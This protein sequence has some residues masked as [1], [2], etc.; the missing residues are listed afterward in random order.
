MAAN[1]FLNFQGTKKATFVGTNSNVV[2][3]TLNSSLG[4]GV[5]ENGPTSNLHVVGNAYV[6]TGLTVGGTTT[7]TAFAGP[8]TG[9]VTGDGSGLTA[10][11][12]TNIA[13]GT[14]TAARI[15]D[16]WSNLASNVVRIETLET[17]NTVQ[18]GLITTL[19]TDVTDNASRITTLE[20]DV[21]DNASRITTLETDVTDNAS[22]ITTLESANTVQGGLI[23]A[24]ETDVTDNASRITTL[25]S[26]NAI[27]G[28]L[29]TAIETDVTDNASRITTLESANTVQGG[30]ITAIETD[31]TDNA[32]RITTLESANAIQG[33][34][35]TAIETDV[36][37]NASRI[38]TLESANAIQG[39]LIT[40]IE[41]DVASNASKIAF[42]T[43]T[44]D[45]TSIA[46]NLNVTGN[47]GIGT[48][49]P[50]SQFEVQGAGQTETTTFNQAGALGGTLALRDSGTSA[51]NGGAIMFGAPQGFWSAIKANMVDG[52]SNSIGALSFFTRNATGDSTMTN[53][54]TIL[55]TGNVGIGTGA[56]GA[57]LD[58]YKNSTNGAAINFES[59]G[60]YQTTIGQKSSGVGDRA[61][62]FTSYG[63]AATSNPVYNFL[64]LNSDA[65]AYNTIL[66]MTGNGNV[67]IGATDPKTRLHV[68]H[69]LHLQANSE[70]WNTTA[71]KGLYLR[72]SLT[73]GQDSAYIQSIDRTNTGT[74]YP[75]IFQAS[76]YD[77]TVGNATFAGNVTAGSF[78]GNAT[79]ATSAGSVT[80]GVYTTGDQTIGGTKTFSGNVTTG[81][82]LYVGTNTNNETAKT[83]Y[84]GGTYGDNG[85]DHCVIER[86][87]WATGTENQELLL[88]SGN[89]T[90]P[91]SGSD[92]IRMKGN[93]IL[94]D[95][96]S[97]ATTDREA[98]TTKMKIDQ[99]GNVDI[100]NGRLRI[101]NLPIA[102]LS[103]SRNATLTN[104]D[105][106]SANFYNKTWLNNGN[107]FNA[108]TGRFTCPGPGIYRIYFRVTATLGT[109]VRLRKNGSGINE[110]YAASDTAQR[111]VSSEAV[112]ECVEN[113]YLHIQVNSLTP[114]GGTQHCQVTFQQL[115]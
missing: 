44:V 45:T 97:T 62:Q 101:H 108:S 7:A 91:G 49:A 92:R 47:V 60:G 57:L 114:Q 79:S 12:A 2:I 65:S 106:T 90:D 48:V 99:N 6:S 98:E 9:A 63:S 113:D 5:D 70:D 14:L 38:T 67:G 20:T 54:M 111:S 8:L 85:Y 87:I 10:L 33:G 115:G 105:L 78:L 76:S 41:T 75:M 32:S 59:S 89:D 110:A 61:L 58:L 19:E 16:I 35:I 40:A 73:G 74:S 39:G 100:L 56:P 28:G 34:L 81:P 82:I 77:F 88:F 22:R 43:S 17:A 94:F 18:G 107:H 1:G 102:S 31:V 15:P 84:F 51:G 93:T 69:D 27:Q 29:I 42:I 80:N 36:T 95:T 64:A 55:N 25:E 103:D 68:N 96:Y 66:T 23:T 37:D 52:T 109:N 86:R 104:V 11:N 13:S 30:L 72:Y 21:T 26:A 24:I 53:R 50:V 83:I 71:G 46:S 4:I 3:N 112:I